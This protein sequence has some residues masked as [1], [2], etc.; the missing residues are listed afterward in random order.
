MSNRSH[1]QERILAILAE[2]PAGLAAENLLAAVCP[3]GSRAERI[4]MLRTLRRLEE[5]GRLSIEG[6]RHR[7]EVAG[8]LVVANPPPMA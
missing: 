3:R 1:R 7:T 2:H 6:R 8:A 4:R 5:G